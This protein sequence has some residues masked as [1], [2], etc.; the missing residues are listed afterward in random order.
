MNKKETNYIYLILG[1]IVLVIVT[2]GV[3]YA[4]VKDPKKDNKVTDN[5]ENITD[6]PTE[7]NE[8]I[9]LTNKELEKY[10]SY[11]PNINAEIEEGKTGSVYKNPSNV[12]DI[13]KNILLGKTLGYLYEKCSENESC[14]KAQ[15]PKEDLNLDAIRKSELDKELYTRYN[16]SKYKVEEY[17]ENNETNDYIADSNGFCYYY[18]ENYFSIVECFGGGPGFELSKVDSYNIENGDL[19]IYEYHAEA[20]LISDGVDDKLKIYDLQNE[21]IEVFLEDD[22]DKAESYFENNKEKFTKYKHTFKKNDKD[23]YWY[24][25]EVA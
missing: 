14:Y 1:I 4:I 12:I 13:N 8:K 7:D 5:N 10:L 17:D 2:A 24:S 15:S 11:V 20:V 23:Y 18:T 25:T 22:E 16:I 6:K 19:V 9:T 3:T 21:E